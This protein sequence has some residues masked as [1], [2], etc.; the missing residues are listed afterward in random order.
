MDVRIQVGDEAEI[1]WD[2][3]WPDEALRRHVG[4]VWAQNLDEDY[5]DTPIYL[6]MVTDFGRDPL[7]GR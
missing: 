2:G 3:E 5:L 6:S 4:K 7:A 1:I